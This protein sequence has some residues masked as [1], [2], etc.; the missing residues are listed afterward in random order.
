MS[1]QSGSCSAV[2]TCRRCPRAF[3]LIEIIIVVAILGILAAI[4]I[5]HFTSA[6]DQAR[7]SSLEMDLYRIRTQIQVYHA[8]HNDTYPSLDS[9]VDQMTKASN[10]QGQ[11]A[12]AG[13]PGYSYGPY[14]RDMPVN[15][16][17]SGSKLGS[18]GVG[19]SDWYYDETTGDFRANDSATSR[20]N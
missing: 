17:T 14:L 1:N 4:T 7:G 13:T 5:P 10:A 3:T 12:A 8:Q 20:A 2:A 15:P 16:K 19:T 9:F 6:A 11:T 18:G